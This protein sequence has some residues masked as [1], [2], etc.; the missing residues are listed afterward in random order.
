[1]FFTVLTQDHTGIAILN[2]ETLIGYV[3][4]FDYASDLSELCEKR[5][6]SMGFAIGKAHQNHGYG[7]ETLATMTA[8]LKQMFDYCVVDHFVGNEPSRKVIEK[9]GYRYFETYTMFFEALGKEMA[10][11]SYMC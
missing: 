2:G 8:Y 5:G 7:T 4:V 9:C 11:F 3:H 10:C 6:V 1:M